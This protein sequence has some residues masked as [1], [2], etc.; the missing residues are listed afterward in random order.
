MENNSNEAFDLVSKSK[1]TLDVYRLSVALLDVEYHAVGHFD[2]DRKVFVVDQ[3][4][5]KPLTEEARQRCKQTLKPFA[6]DYQ[7]FLRGAKAINKY[8]LERLKAW[9]PKLE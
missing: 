7:N 1:F 8:E 6:F 3:F 4:G 9:I 5:M 2:K